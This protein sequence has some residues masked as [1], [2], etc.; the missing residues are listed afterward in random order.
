MPTIEEVRKSKRELERTIL[1]AVRDFEKDGLIVDHINIDRDYEA[2]VHEMRP[3][4]VDM[5]DNSPI[6]SVSVSLQ[7]DFD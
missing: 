3:I 6:K 2:R 5:E 7:I 1:D 4:P